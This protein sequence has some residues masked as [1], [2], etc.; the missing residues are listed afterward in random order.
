MSEKNIQEARKELQSF[1]IELFKKKLKPDSPQTRKKVE[2]KVE[3]ILT[4]YAIKR[5]DLLQLK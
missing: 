4:T 1:Y 5:E 2:A 3:T